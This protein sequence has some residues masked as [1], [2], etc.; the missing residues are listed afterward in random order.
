MGTTHRE[1]LGILL[2]TQRQTV[3][4]SVIGAV[5]IAWLVVPYLAAEVVLLW[6]GVAVA[7]VVW[8]FLV[9]GAGLRQGDDAVSLVP[10]ERRLA[11]AACVNAVILATPLV[12]LAERLPDGVS[13]ALG[14]VSVALAGGAGVTLLASTLVFHAYVLPLLSLT[15]LAYLRH[16]EVDLT[17][18]KAVQG[19]AIVVFICGILSVHR[20]MHRYL[21]RILALRQ[22]KESM[23]RDKEALLIRLEMD[24]AELLADRDAFLI[25]SLTDSLT[26]LANRRHF[27][28]TLARDWERARRE[29]MALSCIMLDVDHF[30]PYNDRHGHGAGDASLKAVAEAITAALNRGSD[31]AARYGGEEFV[32]LLP[33]T[34]LP[35][36]ALLAERIRRTIADMQFVEGARLTVSAGAASVMPDGARPAQYL[37]Q[38]ADDALYQAKAKGRN[39]VV[40]RGD[41][42]ARTGGDTGEPLMDSA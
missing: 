27:D 39:Q 30:K 16:A 36:A 32:I 22:E 9:A 33:G 24:N 8:R 25:A 3:W 41:V 38:L 15:A 14:W 34:E 11:L 21:V 13:H 10:W 40:S 31:F 37:L 42:V 18:L 4:F 7:A 29:G 26:G 28:K 20:L 17:D 19:I 23:L 12:F 5:V 6:L 1:I 35:G 2:R